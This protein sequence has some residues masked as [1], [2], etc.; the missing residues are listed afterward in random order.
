MNASVEVYPSQNYLGGDKPKGFARSLYYVGNSHASVGQSPEQQEVQAARVLGQAAI[1]D[2]KAANALRTFDTWYPEFANHG[3]PI[4]VEPAGANLEVQ[5][6]F[7]PGAASAFSLAKQ[8]NTLDPDSDN[9]MFMIACLVR[10]G[11]Y[12]ER[13]DS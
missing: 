10:G 12:S 13:G 7:R 11:V 5:R 9:G 6:F 3:Q 1:R 8:L 4:A 2:T